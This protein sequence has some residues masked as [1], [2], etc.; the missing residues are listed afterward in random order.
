MHG[1]SKGGSVFCDPS[2]H[3]VDQKAKETQAIDEA[4]NLKRPGVQT[5]AEGVN[6]ERGSVSTPMVSNQL[7][8]TLWPWFAPMAGNIVAL[9][10]Q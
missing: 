4:S 6:L 1:V 8:L 7:L 9:K 2:Q 5:I 3:R 10:L